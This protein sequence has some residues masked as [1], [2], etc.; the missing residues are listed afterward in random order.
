MADEARTAADRDGDARVAELERALA[1][2]DAEIAALRAQVAQ[3]GKLV[4]ELSEKLNQNSRNSH[5]PPSSDGPG[6]G[7]RGA[8]TPKK[9]ESNRKRGGQKGHRGAH[10]ELMAPVDEFFDLFPEVCLGCGANLPEVLDADAR[11]YQQVELR[12]H[13][14]HV[15]EYRRHE[16]E[17]PRCGAS[18]Q[19]AYDPSRIPAFAFGPCLTAVV[20]LLTGVY[21]LSRRK[22]QRL[23]LELFDI[24]VSLG[25]LSAMERR[26]S[27]ALATA[28]DEAKREV[29][30]AGVKHTDATSWSRSGALMSLWT[31]ASV[32]ATVYRIFANGA[33][34]TVRPFFGR[35][36]GILVSDRASVF[37]F[38]RMI[39]RQICWAHLIRKFIA[40]SERD[41]PAGE[42]G[43]ELLGYAKLVF[44]YWQG[45][46]DGVLTREELI[47]WMGPVRREFELALARAAIADI[48]RLSRSCANMLAHR[49][50][51]WSFVKRDGVE[52][53]NNEAERALRAFVLWRKGSFGT[54][55]ERGERFAERLMTVAETARKQGKAVL[56]FIT[57]SVRARLDGMEP[58]KLIA[59]PTGA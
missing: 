40:F 50:A 21:H 31:I 51:L 41:G 47:S 52:P 18:T 42:I 55:S 14:R 17:C 44:E 1:E 36:R 26:A 6:A 59:A 4:T 9:N 23:L 39:Y 16:V 56:E 45:F 25:A 28:Y 58:P 10:R 43:R 48:P 54:Q 29:R 34:D 27:E 19:A 7:S 12:D 33:R 38:W 11:R 37:T 30:H 35:R 53:T 20:G 15:T 57:Q 3:L 32:T 13:R 5:L 46:K 22:A 2:R 8:P 49:E 24:S